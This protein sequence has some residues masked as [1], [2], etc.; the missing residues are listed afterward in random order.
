MVLAA[1]S[2]ENSSAPVALFGAFPVSYS[3]T[4]DLPRDCSPHADFRPGVKQT[5]VRGG[6]PCKQTIPDGFL[7]VT[8]LEEQGESCTPRE[9]EHLANDGYEE[10]LSGTG[11]VARKSTAKRCA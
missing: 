11:C 3:P 7:K 1:D 8:R 4:S 10:G 2:L 5:L 6:V 9:G